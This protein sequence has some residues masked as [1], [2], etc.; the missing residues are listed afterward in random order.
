MKGSGFTEKHSK[1]Q[2]IYVVC[3]LNIH[4]SQ[5]NFL[6]TTA[7]R[8]VLQEKHSWKEISNQGHTCI[9]SQVAVQTW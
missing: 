6:C 4:H 7:W 8:K 2:N 3:P 9:K 1:W 5:K